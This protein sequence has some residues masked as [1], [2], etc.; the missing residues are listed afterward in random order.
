[1]VAPVQL[2][3]LKEQEQPEPK[4]DTTKKP[5]KLLVIIVIVFLIVMFCTLRSASQPTK[6]AWR[7]KPTLSSL[8]LPQPHLRHKPL[9]SLKPE[10]R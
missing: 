10:L 2:N 9:V 6:T 7:Q 3:P 8:V 5:F 4:P 1:M